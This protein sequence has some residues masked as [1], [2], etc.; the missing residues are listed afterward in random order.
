MNS[1]N[2]LNEFRREDLKYYFSD[3]T[4]LRMMLHIVI[5]AITD[6][7]LNA[8]ERYLITMYLVVGLNYK[9]IAEVLGVTS[10]TVSRRINKIIRKIAVQ[11]IDK[12]R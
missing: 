3:I 2:D 12:N 9:E 10:E 7:N 11:L 6:A 5:K 4:R 1:I 8:D